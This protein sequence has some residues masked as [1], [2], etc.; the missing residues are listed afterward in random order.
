MPEDEEDLTLTQE[1]LIHRNAQEASVILNSLNPKE[2]NKIE[3]LEGKLGRFMM[4]DD[5][6]PQEMYDQMMVI[7]N[8]FRGLRSEDM[9]DHVVVKRLLR[10]ISPR[11]PILVTLICESNGFKRMTP[12]DVL[13]RIISHE[14]LEEEAKEVKKYATNA[15]QAKDKEVAFKA[16]KTS[17]KLQEKRSSGSDT[18]CPKLAKNKEGKGKTKYF[19][20]RLGRARIGEEWFSSDNESDKEE[21]PKSS[22]SKSKGVATVAISSSSMERLFSN[23]SDDDNDHI[24]LCLMAQGRKPA[25][26]HIAKLMKVLEEKECSLERQEDLLIQER[27]END[28]LE[29]V[30]AEKDEKLIE[31]SKEL[32]LANQT[33]TNLKDVNEILEKT[34]LSMNVR[35]NGLE[36]E[37]DNLKRNLSN[38][39]DNTIVNTILE[40]EKCKTIDLSVVETN[41]AALEELKKENE[42]LETLV[43]FGCIRTYQSKEALFKTITTHHNKDK[44]GLGYSPN[45]NT[46]S[47]RVMINGKSCLVFVKEG[48]SKVEEEGKMSTEAYSSGGSSW[49][50][51]SGCTNHMT[52]ERNM[53]T[54]LDKDS[55]D[56]D[57]IIF[58]DDSK[59]KGIKHEFSAPYDPPQN[60]IVERKNRTLIEMARTMLDEYKTPDVFWAK[61]V[62]TACHSLN[63]LYLHKLLKKT[64]YELLISK[65][66]NVSYFRVFGCKCFILSKRPRSSKFPSKV[67]E[68]FLLGYE[69]NA[70]AYRVFN[71]T[72]DIVEVSR[73]VK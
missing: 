53:F 8:K 5:E 61:A 25:L 59:G 17:L 2:F 69:A 43:K 19:K 52:G 45:I 10:A 23:L 65:K 20:R 46:S 24:P 16:K 68:G 47:K 35:Q 27:M 15:V 22:D 56:C 1:L 50:I 6:T 9:T 70:R 54:L 55:R 32:M 48:E 28:S 39:K 66:P 38:S 11:N 51:D 13:S 67:D 63:R 40:C 49:V 3:L 42:R 36:N 71:K 34:I 26:I 7:V 73:D 31:L 29:K 62:N 57:D 60:R 64:A 18:D 30:L 37:I 4:E 14:L 21:K 41:D 12:S 58:G 72:I 44:R 33:V